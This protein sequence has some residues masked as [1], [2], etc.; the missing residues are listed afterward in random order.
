VIEDVSAWG[1]L[2]TVLAI[3]FGLAAIGSLFTMVIAT[4]QEHHTVAAYAERVMGITA[5]GTFV[6]SVL[7]IN[8]VRDE[9]L[10]AI[11]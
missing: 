6:F 11:C 8:Y 4:R 2:Y 10:R 9:F 1:E 5:L 7:S 3:L